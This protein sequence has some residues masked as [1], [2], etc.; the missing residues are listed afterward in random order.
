MLAAMDSCFGVV[1]RQGLLYISELAALATSVS[2]KLLLFFCVKNQGLAPTP[3][4]DI[5]FHFH[6]FQLL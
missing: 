6:N 2:Y 1:E 4:I 5:F 3:F